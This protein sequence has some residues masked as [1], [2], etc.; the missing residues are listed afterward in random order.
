MIDWESILRR[1]GPAVWRTAWR[2]LGDRND[3]DECFQE[4]FVAALEYSR[5]PGRQAIQHWRAFLQRIA[6]TRAIDRLRRR[7]SQRERVAVLPDE[8]PSNGR[9]PQDELESS[10]LS[11]RLRAA[12]ARLPEGQAEAFCLFHLEGWSYREIAESLSISTDLVGVWLQRAKARLRELLS[13]V[14]PTARA[15]KEVSHE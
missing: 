15:A 6:T 10:E 3:A 4:A 2:V 9:L 13:S 8:F 7:A 12:L 11:A 14:D 1:D 5:V